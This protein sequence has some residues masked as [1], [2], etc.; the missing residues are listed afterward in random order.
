MDADDAD[1]ADKVMLRNEPQD[2][3]FTNV[4]LIPFF[5]P[6]PFIILSF[7]SYFLAFIILS[8]F[9]VPGRNK[10]HLNRR[11]GSSVME[12]KRTVSIIGLALVDIS[13]FFA[14]APAKTKTAEG[15]PGV[16]FFSILKWTDS[17]VWQQLA[18]SSLKTSSLTNIDL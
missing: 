17:N 10:H 4:N 11:I 18:P 3:R 12:L 7:S 6:F 2:A 1:E 16:V 5:N 14:T 9:T 13:C 15:G 8:F